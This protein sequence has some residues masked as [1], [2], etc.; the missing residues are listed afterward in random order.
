[1]TLNERFIGM[2]GGGTK[3]TCTIGTADGRVLAMA[4]GASSNIQSKPLS[5]VVEVITG[6]IDD[7]LRQSDS[8][9]SQLTIVYMALAGSAREED[10]A[11]IRTALQARMP[12]RVT[13]V[14]DH[15]AKGA[16]AAGTWHETGLVLIA[17]TGSIVYAF[18]SAEVEPIRVGGWGYLLGDEGSGFDIGK[19][20]ISAVLKEYDGRDTP[21]KMTDLL[22]EH[23]G[24]TDPGDMI[25]AIYGAEN[26]RGNIAT[27]AKIVFSA[28]ENG[29]EVA[30]D[31]LDDAK[32]NLLRLVE[33]AYRRLPESASHV[34][35]VSGG[36]FQ[37]KWFRETFDASVRKRTKG[38]SPIY[39]TRPPVIGSFTLALKQAGVK[40]TDEVKTTIAN[41]RV[42]S[43]EGGMDRSGNA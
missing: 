14:I 37:N 11:K 17:G 34:L 7:V 15:D 4:S 13:C 35:V 40:L 22:L 12:E 36:V 41:Y 29:D 31:I 38:L 25:P 23:L 2:D 5:D 43:T 20:G 39:P 42:D 6:L 33:G 8:A 18:Q 10:K 32:E 3:T 19:Q 28:A 16:L 1:M 26:V 9:Y 24:R 21:T 27:V 30:Q